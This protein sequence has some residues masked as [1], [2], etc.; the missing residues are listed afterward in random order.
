[1]II[2]IIIIIINYYY[3]VTSSVFNSAV[4]LSQHM[5]G[6]HKSTLKKSFSQLIINLHFNSW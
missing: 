5:M 4:A 6:V 2:I 3:Y 1:M